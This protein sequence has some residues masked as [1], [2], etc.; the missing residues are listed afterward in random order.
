MPKQIAMCYSY[1]QLMILE[2]LFLH[3]HVCRVDSL[4]YL[5]VTVNEGI[6]K[7]LIMLVKRKGINFPWLDSKFDPGGHNTIGLLNLV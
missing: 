7:T 2:E 4:N 5:H 1:K 3:L 6:S